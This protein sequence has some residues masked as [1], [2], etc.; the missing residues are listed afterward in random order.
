MR[1]Y[2]AVG[3][4]EKFHVSRGIKWEEEQTVAIFRVPRK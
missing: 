1:L 3:D 4:L 2:V